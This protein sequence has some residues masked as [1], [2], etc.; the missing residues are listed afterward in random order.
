MEPSFDELRERLAEAES[1][2]S[3]FYYGNDDGQTSKSRAKAF[4][5]KRL[6]G[7]KP[8]RLTYSVLCLTVPKKTAFAIQA[9]ARE[10]GMGVNA[11]ALYFLRRGLENR[12]QQ[13]LRAQK[14][15]IAKE[16]FQ[17]RQQRRKFVA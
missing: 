6:R 14:D 7:S 9:A 1:I 4:I 11:M 10:E 15:W 13:L 16:E 8:A 2:I 5:D 12:K 17:K 3:G